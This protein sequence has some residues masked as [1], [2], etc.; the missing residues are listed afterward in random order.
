VSEIFEYVPE[1]QPAKPTWKERVS[2]F[3]RILIPPVLAA[4]ILFALLVVLQVVGFAPESIVSTS[5]SATQP[6]P[7]PFTV[8]VGDLESNH[9]VVIN[10]K[11]E[12]SKF[13]EA[14]VG[15]RVLGTDMSSMDGSFEIELSVPPPYSQI[16]VR[17]QDQNG[18]WRVTKNQ[19]SNWAA[20]VNL[21][22]EIKLATYIPEKHLLWIAGQCFANTSFVRLLGDKELLSIIYNLQV[23]GSFETLIL[24]KDL[25]PRMIQAGKDTLEQVI[26]SPFTVTQTSLVDLPLSRQTLVEFGNGVLNFHLN[27]L[28]PAQHPAFINLVQGYISAEEFIADSVGRFYISPSTSYTTTLSTENGLGKVDIIATSPYMPTQFSLEAD[29][30]NGISTYPFL[31]D[32]DRLEL[33]FTRIHPAWYGDLMPNELKADSAIWQGPI[34]LTEFTGPTVGISREDI[35]RLRYPEKPEE[36]SPTSTGVPVNTAHY[37]ANQQKM[38]DF[39]ASF[40]YRQVADLLY[41]I[42][43]MLT[44]LIPVAGLYFILQQTSLIHPN[45][46]KAIWA[47]VLIL[48]FWRCWGVFSYLLFTENTWLQHLITPVRYLVGLGGIPFEREKLIASAGYFAFWLIFIMLTVVAPRMQAK[49]EIWDDQ[50]LSQPKPDRWKRLRWIGIILRILWIIVL[51]FV[52]YWLNYGGNGPYQ[53]LNLLT[54][55][56]SQAVQKMVDKTVWIDILASGEVKGLILIAGV[57][58][59]VLAYNW[60]AALSV[61]GLEAIA[62]RGAIPLLLAERSIFG[63]TS[64]YGLM[65]FKA[66]TTSIQFPDR[67]LKL[68]ITINKVPWWVFLLFGGVM[69]FPL[70]LFCLKRLTPP[71]EKGTGLGSRFIFTI[72]LVGLAILM[73]HLPAKSFLVGGGTIYLTSLCW[74]VFSG[75]RHFEPIHRFT[76]W[77]E[78]HKKAVLT[79]LI[80]LSA[81]IT[82]PMTKTQTTL[83]S[84]NDLS[85]LVGSLT[86]LLIFIMAF[87]V[88]LIFR[89]YMI[90]HKGEVTLDTKMIVA[91]TIFF[92]IFLV[93]SP[94]RWLFIP[95]PYL[96]GWLIARFLLFHPQSY[97]NGLENKKGEFLKQRKDKIRL[98][99]QGGSTRARYDTLRK[100]LNKRVEDGKEALDEYEKKLDEYNKRR[101]EALASIP[102]L[103]EIFIISEPDTWTNVKQYLKYGAILA[104][105][106]LLISLYDYLPQS[107]VNYPYPLVD[108]ISFLVRTIAA[109]LIYAF[110]FGIFYTHIRGSSGLTKGLYLWLALVIPLLAYR[111]LRTPTWTDLSFFVFW[112]AQVLLFLTLL[113][114]FGTDLQLLQQ[115]G[116]RF[117]DLFTVYNLSVLSIYG[118]TILAAIASSIPALISGKLPDLFKWLVNLFQGTP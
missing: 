51:L 97:L 92:A 54:Q 77:V 61:V 95:V 13:V 76:D 106:P 43:T 20:Q 98:L 52:L 66:D 47:M 112:M 72:L 53:A 44:L 46:K 12:P 62:I 115:A 89:E 105:I 58:L 100:G 31:T 6:Q 9:K 55:P 93:N 32:K 28:L 38:N 64:L 48:A 68:F 2:F 74:V 73:P 26:S 111:L 40:E 18:D 107:L 110:F 10:G 83:F 42:V 37:Q 113:G 102:A 5:E 22:P 108:A 1:E 79:G 60:R 94:A 118:S 57:A 80:V 90:Q 16:W 21:A 104:V 14:G 49:L 33:V 70:V 65:G 41:W 96:L 63:K 19:D 85:E 75:L 3:V 7:L 69:A 11:A 88:V 35:E 34:T 101:S 109:W 27:V 30:R 17:S 86:G 91:G 103:D 50:S 29:Y 67:V 56:V 71:T 78:D 15:E 24:I 36:P 23:D 8:E 81:G 59:L 84:F 117:R 87:V 25:P 99:V 4:I 82:W 114:I 39:L 116:Y 45:A